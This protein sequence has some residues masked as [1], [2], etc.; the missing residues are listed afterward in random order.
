MT[1][2]AA[3]N[4]ISISQINS[5]FGLGNSLSSYRG[6][7]WYTDAGGS[8]TFDSTNLD[9]SEFY[10]K[11]ATPAVTISLTSLGSFFMAE[12]QYSGSNI[13]GQLDFNRNGTW[14]WYGITNNSS[15]S[16]ATPNATDRGDSY[17]IRFTRTAFSDGLY[18]YATASTGWLQ[19]STFRSI[20]VG[21]PLPGTTSA[22]YTIEISSSSGGSPVLATNSGLQ[23]D[24]Q[25]N[26]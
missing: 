24:V 3:G 14:N 23:I 9:M 1:L 8:G 22:T 26:N 4:P 25:I 6:V 16:W 13:Q 18:A 10:S 17:W 11:R 15:G 5:E 12:D 7:T 19:I 20:I 21:S 2:P